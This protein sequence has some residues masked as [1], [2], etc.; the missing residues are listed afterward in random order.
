MNLRRLLHTT[1]IRL[2]LRY[3]LFYA[4][5]ITLGLGILYWATSRYVDVQMAAGLEQNWRVLFK[6]SVNPDTIIYLPLLM[7][8]NRLLMA[9]IDAITCCN[10]GLVSD[11]PAG[12]SI[13]RRALPRTTGF[14][15]S[16]SKIS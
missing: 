12:Y 14:A 4:L 5:L 3:A 2:A 13:G 8:S 7:P 11:W 15:M 1:A 16:G 10:P 6:L 9:T